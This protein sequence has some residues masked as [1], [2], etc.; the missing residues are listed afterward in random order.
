MVANYCDVVLETADDLEAASR[1]RWKYFVENTLQKSPQLRT[2]I[3]TY[4][5]WYSD[6]L[7]KLV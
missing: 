2:F 4:R 1:E 6:K 7:T 5:A 3:S